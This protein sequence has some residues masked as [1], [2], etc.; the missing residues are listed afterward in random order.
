MKT[1]RFNTFLLL[2][3]VIVTFLFGCTDKKEDNGPA[4]NNEDSVYIFVDEVMKYWYLWN[5][6]VPDLDIFQYS[7]PQDLLDDLMYKPLDHWSFIDKL[8]AIQ[9]LFEEGE[10]FGF[11]FLLKFDADGN[12]RVPLVYENSEA[13]DLGIRRGNIVST[14]NGIPAISFDDYE[15]FFDYDPATFTFEIYDNTGTLKTITLDKSTITQNAVLFSNIYTIS[16]HKTGYIVYDSFLGYSK[17]ELEEVITYFQANNI[18]ELILDIRYNGGGYVSLA[19][20][21]CEIIM[22]AETAG[23]IFYTSIHNEI[24]GPELDTTLYFSENELNLDLNR[25]FFIT[26]SASASA[27]ELV[28]NSLE[29]Y[30]EVF[31]IGSPTHGKPVG[32]Y[33]FVFQDWALFPITT[34]LLNAEGY[35]DYFGGLMPDCYA[36]DGLT[37][38]WGDETEQSLS[39]AFHYIAYGG[40]DNTLTVNVKSIRSEPSLKQYLNNRSLLILEK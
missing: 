29:P 20:E 23:E 38:D 34:Q 32:M 27:S 16:G 2:I 39:Q 26:T 33:G 21:L 19:Q 24:V 3:L 7:T 18:T 10:Y 9:S 30:M 22:P 17:E 40:F 4:D 1:Q 15:S 8:D 37:S 36:E 11:G 25:V 12:L 5:D 28:I 35:G 14:I 13:Y 6:K 31:I